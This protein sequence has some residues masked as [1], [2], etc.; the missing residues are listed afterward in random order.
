ML[1]VTNSYWFRKSYLSKLCFIIIC[2]E[3]KQKVL[4]LNSSEKFIIF[5]ANI[6]HVRFN[7][8]NS[9][10]RYCRCL[11]IFFGLVKMTFGLVDA[12]YSLPEGQAVKLTFFAP[13]WHSCFTILDVRSLIRECVQISASGHA[14]AGQSG[15]NFFRFCFQ[16]VPILSGLNE[17]ESETGQNSLSGQLTEVTKSWLISVSLCQRVE[18]VSHTALLT[19]II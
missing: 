10:H 14:D 1:L 9:K 12:S 18:I 15:T 16:S 2:Q 4:I 13:C 8:V 19:K 5:L 17:T 11:L 7:M 3:R 6:R